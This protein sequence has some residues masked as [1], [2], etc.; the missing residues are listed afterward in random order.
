MAKLPAPTTAGF[1]AGKNYY[2][3]PF[4]IDDIIIDSE[5]SRIFKIQDKT[6]DEIKQKIKAFGYDKSQ[7]VVLQKGTNILLDGHTRLAAAKAAGLEEIPAVEMEFEDREEAILYTFER[8]VLRRNLTG[9]EILTAA[10]MI[11]GRKATDGKGR[12]AEILAE[13]LKVSPSTVYQ[14]RAI[15]KESPPEDIEAVMNGDASIKATYNKLLE[16]KKKPSEE[17]NNSKLPEISLKLEAAVILL[18]QAKHAPA[19]KLLIDHY[20]R[21]KERSEFYKLLPGEIRDAQLE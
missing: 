17:N 21:K 3:R 10:K 19:A 15:L 13:K 11:H 12:A 6:L 20:L 4:P 8:Q 14:G 5:I 16:S 18:V 1:N 9:S 7:P 2:A